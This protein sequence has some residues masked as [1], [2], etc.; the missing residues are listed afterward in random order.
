MGHLD[1]RIVVI[2]GAGNGIG[3]E[4]TLL[5]AR[6]GAR[7]VVNDL[8]SSVAGEGHDESAAAS[9]VEE[10]RGFG[11]EAVANHGDVATAEGAQS[12]VQQALDTFGAL[13]VLV[14]NAGILRDRMVA[15]MTDDD[16]DD[17]IR[18][19]LRGHF[20]P[21]RAA[22]GYWRAEAKAERPRKASVINTSSTSGLRGRVGQS[23]YGS[24]KAA[25][26]SLTVIA[27]Q[28]LGKSGVRVNA[29]A[30]GARTRMTE[31]MMPASTDDGSFDRYSPANI[32]PLVAYLATE[33][34][35]EH[36]RVYFVHGAYVGL[37]QPWHVVG[38]I[39]QEDR[40]DVGELAD[41]HA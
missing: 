25:I 22:A 1:D 18:V 34:A 27:D 20:C 39:E 4:H 10:I 32:S 2:T 16:W 17:V 6:E 19:H 24:A 41:P 23:N 15:N 29:I 36:G 21:L 37:L 26:A 9:V 28:E 38:T 5:M 11:G 13:D 33:D 40:W 31:S 30:P 12:L 35:P 7:V 3:R 8:G 14:N